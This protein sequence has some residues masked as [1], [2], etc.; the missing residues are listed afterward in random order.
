[1][2]SIFKKIT[3]PI[4]ILFTLSIATVLIMATISMNTLIIPDIEKM[5]EDLLESKASEITYFFQTKIEEIESLAQTYDSSLSESTNLE[6]IALFNSVNNRYESLGIITLDGM[7]QLTSGVSFSIE[8]RDYFKEIKANG[9]KTYVSNPVQSLENAE[10]IVII[11]SEIK[12]NNEVIAYLSGAINI[13]YIQKVIED[14]NTF[15]FPTQIVDGKTNEIIM[16]TS[17]EITENS[18][19]FES[20]LHTNN[21]WLLKIYVPDTFIQRHFVTFYVVIFITSL[22][23]LFFVILVIR[24]RMKKT[25]RPI[26]DLVKEM[27]QVDQNHLKEVAVNTDSI[28]MH[29]LSDSYNQMIQTIKN[30]ISEIEISEKKKKE[31]EYKALIQQIKPHFLYNTL[32]MIQSMCIDLDDDRIETTIGLLSNYFRISLSNDALFIPLA[33]ELKQV[34]SYLEIQKLRYAEQFDYRIIE[35]ADHSLNFLKFTLQPLIENAIYHGVKVSNKKEWIEIHTWEDEDNIYVQVSNTYESIH[36]EKIK[37]LN[38]LFPLKGHQDAYSGYGLYN[39]N[40]RLKLNFSDTEHLV[41]GYDEQKVWVLV[42]HP[43]VRVK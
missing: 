3:T 41:M 16:E 19:L 7:K 38:S 26:Q 17:Y 42:K 20:D 22:L 29:A 43:K 9:Y 21:Q 36:E 23:L 33:Q 31:S 11:I 34:K 32:E 13:N 28:E 39:V 6:R 24:R 2:K 5:S 10:Q 30:L 4:I 8:N 1:M 14:S 37:Q 15:L 27:T 25:L 18:H 40:E 35:E 12:E